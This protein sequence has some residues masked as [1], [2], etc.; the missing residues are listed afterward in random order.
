MKS[1]KYMD[2]ALRSSDPRFAKALSKLGYKAS[3]PAQPVKA[4]K[5]KPQKSDP[6]DHDLDGR[7]GGASKPVDAPDVMG[8][9]RSEY[10]EKVGRRPFMG[11]DAATLKQKIAD[12]PR[13]ERRDMQAKD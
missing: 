8:A 7:K 1:S 12:A 9:M 4:A 6:M 11:W 5:E 10:E 3:Q 2:R 13:Y